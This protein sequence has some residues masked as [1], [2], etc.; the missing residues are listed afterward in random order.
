V[1]PQ[2]SA[3][4]IAESSDERIVYGDISSQ[5]ESSTESLSVKPKYIDLRADFSFKMIFC[6][7]K[8]I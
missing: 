5:E 7:E 4:N 2:A 3:E 1:T 6:T 8:Y